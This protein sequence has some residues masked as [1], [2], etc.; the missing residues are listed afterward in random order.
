MSPIWT[1]LV[2][3]AL[4]QEVVGAEKVRHQASHYVI[5]NNE[6]L[7]KFISRPLLKWIDENHMEYVLNKVHIGI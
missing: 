5:I 4:L 6:M 2:T 3:Y 1:F 7:R